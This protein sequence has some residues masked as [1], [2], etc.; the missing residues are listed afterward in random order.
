ML[1]PLDLDMGLQIELVKLEL[2][3][4]IER[5]CESHAPMSRPDDFGTESEGLVRFRSLALLA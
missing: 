3:A 4:V 1:A 2:A 5:V